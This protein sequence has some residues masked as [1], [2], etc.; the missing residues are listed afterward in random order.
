MSTI[1]LI[2]YRGTG[3]STLGKWLAEELG[4]VFVDTDEKV[5][6]YLGLGSVMEA[7]D[8]GGRVACCGVRGH[9][10]VA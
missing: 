7:W 4:V 9:S 8:W 2:G 6:E 5:L 1:A 3:K 10:T